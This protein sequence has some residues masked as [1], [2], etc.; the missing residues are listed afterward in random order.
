[1][2][3]HGAARSDVGRFT[4]VARCRIL[5]GM[6]GGKSPDGAQVV[7]IAVLLLMLS[8]SIR[9]WINAQRERPS[10]RPALVLDWK[11]RAYPGGSPVT[12]LNGTT[13]TSP[14]RYWRCTDRGPWGRHWPLIA[15]AHDPSSGI[16]YQVV[17]GLPDAVVLTQAGR[18]CFAN[19]AARAW[20]GEPESGPV[21][22]QLLDDA[23]GDESRFPG[24]QS[25]R[26]DDGQVRLLR[27]RKQLLVGQ[28]P[29]VVGWLLDDSAVEANKV[30]PQ[31]QVEIEEAERRRLAAELHDDIGQQLTGLKLH[32][33]LL[34][35][36]AGDEVAVSTMAAQLSEVADELLQ[37]IRRICLGLHPLQLERLGL[38]AAIDLHLQRVATTASIDHQLTVSGDL[39]KVPPA[40]AVVAF[41][42]FQE[43]LSNVLRHARAA[44]VYVE[45]ARCD[46]TLQVRVIDDGVGFEPRDVFTQAMGLGLMAMHERADALGGRLE[47]ASAPGIGTQLSIELPLGGPM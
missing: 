47:V 32:L 35:R 45:L 11:D 12:V 44:H 33:H 36:Q 14:L 10:E 19:T 9:L 7:G 41:R 6:L 38:A 15:V 39:Q 2:L 16:Y 27:V 31:H 24:S 22:H 26:L 20:F 17:N 23:C 13:V 1:M 29:D 40:C 30:S 21:Y 37:G 3:P 42:F 5:L 4:P 18:V 8:V 28:H 34:R 46:E 25:V 43:S